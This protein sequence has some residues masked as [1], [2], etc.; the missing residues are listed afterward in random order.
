MKVFDLKYYEC[1]CKTIYLNP[2]ISENNLTEIYK[3]AGIYEKHRKQILYEK[4]QSY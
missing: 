3:N 1:A 2:T 4:K